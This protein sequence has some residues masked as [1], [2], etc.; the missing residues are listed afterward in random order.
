[1]SPTKVDTCV[2]CGDCDKQVV[3]VK[4]KGLMCEPCRMKDSSSPGKTVSR[5]ETDY[6]QEVFVMGDV[7]QILSK[8]KPLLRLLEMYKGRKLKRQE[9][10]AF[11]EGII[12]RFKETIEKYDKHIER[13][14]RKTILTRALEQPCFKGKKVTALGITSDGIL[15]AKIE[16]KWYAQAPTDKGD[17]IPKLVEVAKVKERRASQA[18]AGK[19][20][21]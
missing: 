8:D 21:L 2:D 18:M 11:F 6:T 20:V 10:I 19:L 7:K 5:V 1:M 16:G 4:K 15:R 17:G 13:F 3:F 9:R 14:E 12:T